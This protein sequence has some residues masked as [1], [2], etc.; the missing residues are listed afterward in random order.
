ME[1]VT[2]IKPKLGDIVVLVARHAPRVG[3]VVDV[4]ISL[5]GEEIY[6]VQLAG[7]HG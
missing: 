4:F 1:G 6:D 5:T 2:E 3:Q 7:A